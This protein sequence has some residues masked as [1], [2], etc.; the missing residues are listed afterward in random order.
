VRLAALIAAYHEAD[1]PVGTLRATLPLAGRT[2]VERQARLAAA[3]GADPIVI[4]VER[5]PPELVAAI[6]RMRIEGISAAVARSPDEAAEAIEPGDRVLVMADGLILDESHVAR[7]SDASAPA[8]LTMDDHAGDGRHER[9]DPHSLWAGLAMVDGQ[10]LR[11]T[12]SSLG[13]WDLQSTLLR[14]AVQSGA[15]QFALRG[16]PADARLVVAERGADLA[17][18]HASIIESASAARGSW[19]SRYLLAPLEQ[20]ATR[21]LMPTAVSSGWLYVSAAMM[22]ALG[23]LLFARGWLG[24]ALGVILL[25]TPLDGIA[26]RL[27]ILRMQPAEPPDWWGYTYPLLSG[28]A[29]AALAYAL[30]PLKGWGCIPIAAAAAAFFIALKVELRGEEMPS[31]QW[32]AEPKA[33]SWLIL[34]FA[35]SGTWIAGLS[36]IAAYAAGSFFWAQRQA[37]APEAGPQQ[38]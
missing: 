12:T 30:V 38:D 36:A 10:M 6:D 31:E 19:V 26:Q 18:V 15:R 3:A 20:F 7:I 23:S 28:L 1:S 13:D 33:M 29:L 21:L 14:L 37:H 25:A 16:D 34:P 4:L 8:V 24:A 9:I 27:A 32:L 2:L 17:E 22:T 35:L 11:R 5:L